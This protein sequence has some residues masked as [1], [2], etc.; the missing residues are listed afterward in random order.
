MIKIT[1]IL[2][3]LDL[4]K[5][6]IRKKSLGF[7]KSCRQRVIFAVLVLFLP[8][9]AVCLS[10]S[11]WLPRRS[12]RLVFLGPRCLVSVQLGP[13]HPGSPPFWNKVYTKASYKEALDESDCWKLFVQHWN[14][15][16]YIYYDNSTNSRAPIGW[17]LSSIS[18]QT[19]EFIINAMQQRARADNLTVC[20]RK[21][22]GRQVFM[23]LS[24]YRQWILS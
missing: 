20:Y 10:I 23:R 15:T 21:K 13:D 24:C 7:S 19:H 4:V 2:V 17:F 18:G 3:S 8:E 14:Y 16:K 5:V 22:N 11:L 12:Y 1:L 6:F 9:F